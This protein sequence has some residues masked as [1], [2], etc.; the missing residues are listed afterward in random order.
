VLKTQGC[1]SKIGSKN[2][3]IARS[4]DNTTTILETKALFICASVF[5]LLKKLTVV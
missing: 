1:Y 5:E 3:D 2:I 4:L